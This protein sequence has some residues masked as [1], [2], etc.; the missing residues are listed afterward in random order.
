MCV[1]VC[2]HGHVYVIVRVCDFVMCCDDRVCL[3]VRV[4]CVSDDVYVK[5]SVF[6]VC[7]CVCACVRACMHVCV[8]RGSWRCIQV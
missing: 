7:V 2:V 3:F 8:G 1:C 5:G 4:E 6:P